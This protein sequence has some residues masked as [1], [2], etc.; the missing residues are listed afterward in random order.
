[1]LDHRTLREERETYHFLYRLILRLY[2]YTY[3]VEEG[4]E[5]GQGGREGGA[6]LEDPIVGKWEGGR[7]GG[8]GGQGGREEQERVLFEDLMEG[9]TEG[10]REGGWGEQKVYSLEY[11]LINPVTYRECLRGG[12]RTTPFAVSLVEAGGRMLIVFRGR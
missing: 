3:E 1:M 9:G 10:R 11:P 4:R 8:Q 12:R 2:K 6:K 7:E 5:E